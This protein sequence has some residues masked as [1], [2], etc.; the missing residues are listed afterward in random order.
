[1]KKELIEYLSQFA[2]ENRVDLFN[3]KIEQRTNHVTLVLED[4]YQAQNTSAAIRTSDCFGIQNVHVIENSNE[5]NVY[6]DITLGSSNWLNINKYN[7]EE[8]NSKA[9]FDSLKKQGYK[10]VATSP[11][12]HHDSVFEFSVDDKIALVLGNELNG[13]SEIAKQEADEFITIPMYG[14]TESFN[15]SVSAALCLSE[16]SKRVR[17]SDIDWKL[18]EE[19]KNDVLIKWY[20]HSIKH[21]KK[22]AKEFKKNFKEK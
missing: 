4:I 19:E 8:N 5:F 9:C 22:L 12:Q 14:F 2:H 10:I 20:K 17:E 6:K 11:L 16:I 18:S 7:K 15:I 13:I 1:M 21:G 3:E